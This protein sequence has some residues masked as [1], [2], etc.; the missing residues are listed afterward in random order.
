MRIDLQFGSVAAS[1]AQ[2]NQVAAGL[3]RVAKA[4]ERV[5]A[6]A[7]AG[8]ARGGGG[9]GSRATSEPRFIAGP[10]QQLNQIAEQRKLLPSLADPI[11]RAAIEKDLDRADDRIRKQ[12]A[13]K[14]PKPVAEPRF[15]S[16]PSQQ[17]ARIAEQRAQLAGIS[18][19]ARRAAIAKDLDI[20][21]FQ[22]RRS[23]ALANRRMQNPDEGLNRPGL[24]EL[25]G[26]LNGLLKSIST[27]NV[28]GSVK[29]LA[30][31]FDLLGGGG[32]NVQQK[33]SR[34]IGAKSAGPSL[35]DFI[36][37]SIGGG[38]GAG[39]LAGTLMGGGG[40]A[41][42]VV[43]ALGGLAG[44]AALAAGVIAG[45][46]A[47]VGLLVEGVKRT[48]AELASFREQVLLTGGTVSQNAALQTFGLGDG[49]AAQF[50][51]GTQVGA[52][53]YA[54]IARARVGLGAVSSSPFARV[55]EAGDLLK[56]IDGLR[57]IT[58][59]N[60]RRLVARQLPGGDRLLALAGMSN[61]A[62]AGMQADARL[63]ARVKGDTRANQ[64]A[65]DL[66]ASVGSYLNSIGQEITLLFRPFMAPLAESFKLIADGMRYAVG[67]WERFSKLPTAVG[68]VF[69]SLSRVF[70]RITG[71]SSKFQLLQRVTDA[72]LVRIEMLAEWLNRLADTIP[73]VV[74]SLAQGV[75]RIADMVK[76]TGAAGALFSAT[77]GKQAE[78][79]IK[80]MNTMIADD[81][82]RKTRD[83]LDRLRDSV[84]H[85][86][87]V[88][89]KSDRVR[90]ALGPSAVTGE[91]R[92][93]A[94][95]AQAL[96]LG[97]WT[98]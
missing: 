54:Q 58:D 9:R 12:L 62:F 66:Q 10:N 68:R 88:F 82:A 48:T 33:L 92:R 55:D 8:G 20:R 17:L 7:P 31:G 75:K 21:D 60:E 34:S 95:E 90:G 77:V 39:G 22:A 27:G 89:G 44:V 28:L 14:P 23:L 98:L 50:R 57:R 81:E 84:D 52:D 3:D 38:K 53:P 42:G 91:M 6:T 74:L 35:S 29:S 1:V 85:A 36:L 86:A 18:D 79:T 49:L 78:D 47:A 71:G 11:R 63:N 97:Y 94:I 40:T 59:E 16:G 61:R 51:Q 4:Q 45:V 80:A 72:V 70:D 2:L 41:G 19:P 65:S 67:Q 5:S 69:V 13:G 76:W 73:Y 24:L 64:D 30:R 15:L 46:V 96:A 87:G 32:L 26:E 83:S 25:F 93:K 56:A 37:P 43:E